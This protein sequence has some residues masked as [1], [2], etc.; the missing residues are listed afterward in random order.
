MSQPHGRWIAGGMLSYVG[1][2]VISFGLVMLCL[3]VREASNPSVLSDGSSPGLPVPFMI[4]LIVLAVPVLLFGNTVRRLGQRMAAPTAEETLA[5]DDRAPVLLL[6]T[7]DDDHAAELGP[8]LDKYHLAFALATGYT[9]KESESKTFEDSLVKVLEERGPVIAIGRPGETLPPS[10]A[11]RMYLADAEWQ[12]KAGE[13]LRSCRLVVLLM[14]R[15]AEHPGLAWEFRQSVALGQ[16]EKV[17]L[18][19]PPVAEPEAKARWEMF[20]KEASWLPPYEGRELGVWLKLPWTATPVVYRAPCN[21]DLAAYKDVIAPKRPASDGTAS[22][23]ACPHCGKM[24]PR[25]FSFCR[26]CDNWL[27]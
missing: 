18:L 8:R 26:H 15:I 21:R 16:P 4:V 27:K 25:T 22:E 20:R 23:K 2:L 24:L 1:G 19:M 3:P 17:L 14:G 9:Y 6:R 5:R 12:A 7:F 11:A 10:G 13:L